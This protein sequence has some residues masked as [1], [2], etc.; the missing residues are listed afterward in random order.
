MNDE[1]LIE[2]A[3]DLWG[4]AIPLERIGTAEDVANVL[5]FLASDDSNYLTG[6]SINC[7]GGCSVA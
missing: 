2:K 4:R 6:Q 1:R 3:L 5:F 7:D